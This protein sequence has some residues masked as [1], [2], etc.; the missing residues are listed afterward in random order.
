VEHQRYI[1][2]GAAHRELEHVLQCG[3]VSQMVQSVPANAVIVLPTMNHRTEWRRAWAQYRATETVPLLFTFPQ[4]YE[5]LFRAGNTDTVQQLQVH[6]CTM[7]LDAA[8]THAGVEFQPSGFNALSV[9]RWKQE[10]LT[11]ATALQL[12]PSDGGV[13]LYPGSEEKIR[14]WEQYEILKGDNTFDYADVVQHVISTVPSIPEKLPQTVLVVA[15]HGLSQ[16][17]RELLCVLRETGVSVGIQFAPAPSEGNSSLEALQWLLLHGFSQPEHQEE[18][19]TEPKL[20]THI[21]QAPTVR[22]EVRRVLGAVKELH[23]AKV[24]LHNIAIVPVVPDIYKPLLMEYAANSVPLAIVNEQK[25]SMCATAQLLHG[26][27]EFHLHGWRTRDLIMLP[28]DGAPQYAP[29]Y[30]ALRDTAEVLRMVGGNGVHEWVERIR[31][32][33]LSSQVM[34]D[35]KKIENIERHLLHSSAE[36]F[37]GALKQL[38]PDT[39]TPERQHLLASLDEYAGSAKRTG[40]IHESAGVHLARWWKIVESITVS[41]LNPDAG[42]IAVVQPNELR[43]LRYEYVFVLGM[44]DGNLPSLREDPVNEL[45]IGRRQRDLEQ[46]QWTDVVTSVTKLLVA[47]YP[48][49]VDDDPT[50]PSQF[51]PNAPQVPSPLKSLTQEYDDVVLN[52]AD[53]RF[54]LDPCE[55]RGEIFQQALQ[56]GDLISETEHYLKTVIEQPISPSR[57]DTAIACPYKYYASAVLKVAETDMPSDDLHPTERGTIF[58]E[59]AREL[60]ES[61]KPTGAIPAGNPAEISEHSVNLEEIDF[62]DLV[63]KACLIYQEKRIRY[64]GGYPMQTVEDGMLVSNGRRSGILSRWLRMEQQVAKDTKFRPWLFE[65]DQFDVELDDYTPPR[66][67]NCKVDRIDVRS[68]DGQLEFMIVDYKLS[69]SSIP[70]VIKIQCGES[71]QA[72]LYIRVVQQWLNN[73]NIPGTVVGMCYHTFGRAARSADDPD[74]RSWLGRQGPSAD[75]V[76]TAAGILVHTRQAA[77]RIRSAYYSVQPLKNAC[78]KCS[79]SEICRVSDYGEAH[80]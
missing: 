43:S 11:P 29:E 25:L 41:S 47:S 30:C 14:I 23:N 78:E 42:S 52:E 21:F 79:Y 16:C 32:N 75:A 80:P 4:L 37:T 38:L 39:E 19:G 15:M 36:R 62:N 35:I 73:K 69:R 13:M 60:F 64:P 77:D 76:D 71:T 27:V 48:A 1:A 24:S 65:F 44:T 22:S 18:A 55:Y 74:T 63:A 68:T 59:V 2:I 51:L 33:N 9:L 50:I 40:L 61:Y 66:K 28:F 34:T 10:G 46:E 5:W 6:E 7:L 31:S 53:R 67:V 45:L 58:H 17:D 12:L 8:L 54:Y 3:T 72:A 26:V 49:F 20:A 57:L 70:A 56:K